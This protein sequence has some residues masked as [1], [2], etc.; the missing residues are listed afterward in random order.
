MR[1]LIMLPCVVLL[2]ATLSAAQNNGTQGAAVK[3]SPMPTERAKATFDDARVRTF[4]TFVNSKELGGK[5]SLPDPGKTLA[6]LTPPPPLPPGVTPDFSSSIYEIQ[7]PCPGNDGL[8]S[9]G[10]RVEFV[11]LVEKPLNLTLS[12]LYRR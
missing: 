5:C 10:I 12:L 11:P 6:V 1:S 3:P 7:L 4:M 2:C 9:V 8:S